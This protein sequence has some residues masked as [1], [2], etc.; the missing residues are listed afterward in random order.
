MRSHLPLSSSSTQLGSGTCQRAI[1]ILNV[2][3]CS[4]EHSNRFRE[5]STV[6]KSYIISSHVRSEQEEVEANFQTKYREL[7]EVPFISL[8]SLH[9]CHL[10]IVQILLFCVCVALVFVFVFCDFLGHDRP[11]PRVWLSRR[12]LCTFK[13]QGTGTPSTP[14][15]Q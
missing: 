15:C 8:I 13:K 10:P 3:I 14:P 11:P 9:D 1:V 6:L 2:L 5:I 7:A 12:T 4:Q